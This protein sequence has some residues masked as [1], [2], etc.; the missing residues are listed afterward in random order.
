[1]T[2]TPLN[3]KAISEGNKKAW[4][5][6]DLKEIYSQAQV[7]SWLNEITRHTRIEKLRAS[8]AKITPKFSE[9]DVWEIRGY[10]SRGATQAELAR[11]YGVS[12]EVMNALARGRTYRW[13][14]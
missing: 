8:G 7:N 5:D 12:P 2:R 11:A 14:V 10:L 3:K 4:A 1:M 6:P 9:A 13:V